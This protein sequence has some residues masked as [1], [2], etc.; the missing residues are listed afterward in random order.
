MT[1]K[2]FLPHIV[3][4]LLLAIIL[5]FPIFQHLK[6]LP[7]VLWD[8]SRLAV[9]AY[10]MQKNGDLIVTHYEGAPDLWNTKPPLMIWCQAACM[11]LFGIN[12][13][14][15]RLPSAIAAL[16]TCFLLLFLS[17]KYLKNYWLGIIASLVL[18]TS[19]GYIDPHASRT[20]DYDALYTMF[21]IAQAFCFFLYIE[22]SQK[23]YLYLFFASLTL[24]VLTKSV[25]GIFFIPGFFLFSLISK[26]FTTL[27]KTKELYI[28]LGIF[29]CF[30]LGYY[31]LRE[32]QNPGF[33]RAVYYNELGGRYLN[34]LEGHHEPFWFYFESIFTFYFAPWYFLIPLG[35]LTGC[36]S[37]EKKMAKLS[38]FLFIVVVSFLF[39]ISIAQTKLIW[40]LIPA[41]P[42]LAIIASV[43]IYLIFNLLREGS[44]IKNKMVSLLIPYVFLIS[45]FW[46][47]YQNIFNKTYKPINY[48]K[49]TYGLSYFLR[50]GLLGKYDLSNSYVLHEGYHAHILFYL[51]I[52]NDKGSNIHFKAQNQLKAGDKIIA[53]QENIHHFI[54]NN[55]DY[56]MINAC[57]HVVMYH[58]IKA[59]EQE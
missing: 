14:S 5:Y 59:K 23:K 54:Q 12:E 18:I 31:F 53:D 49:A 55:Y 17:V 32:Y 43:F 50:D 24:A 30:T 46:M 51:N 47:P 13:F 16:I 21:M 48:D 42:L 28:G 57:D 8:E 1:K 22:H 6:S 29:L 34:T 20:G 10:E 37:K 3:V 45:L 56:N 38:L 15:V 2:Y 11:K 19:Q 9:N 41:Y 7:I 44:F 26:K 40:Y 33:I 35:V 36:F 25:A 58:I 4:F 27:L 39:V 52:L